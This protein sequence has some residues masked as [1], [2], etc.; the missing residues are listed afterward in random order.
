[1][2]HFQRY[3]RQKKKYSEK[4]NTTIT[5]S[6]LYRAISSYG[7]TQR[8]VKH[9][10]SHVNIY[11][12]IFSILFFFLFLLKSATHFHHQ[13]SFKK[14]VFLLSTFNTF[15]QNTLIHALRYSV[16]LKGNFVLPSPTLHMCGKC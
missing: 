9:N 6:Y 16:M 1:M 5:G 12:R 2:K 15:S 4:R 10:K 14:C 13:S 8:H 3:L 11:I 7:F